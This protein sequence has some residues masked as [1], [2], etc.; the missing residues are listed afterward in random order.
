ML[1]TKGFLAL[2]FQYR[3]NGIPGAGCGVPKNL[4]LWVC[5]TKGH[6]LYARKYENKEKEPEFLETL[7]PDFMRG[8]F[9]NSQSFQLL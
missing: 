8:L 5:K 3:D 1:R 2:S 9:R 6:P 7:R 4:S